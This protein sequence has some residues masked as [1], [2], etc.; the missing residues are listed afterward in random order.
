MASL[1]VGLFP[2]RDTKNVQGEAG[3]SGA[4]GLYNGRGGVFRQSFKK[5]LIYKKA[6]KKRKKRNKPGG[7]GTRL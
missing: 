1:W 6:K 5:V 7:S 4:G 3:V 2:P